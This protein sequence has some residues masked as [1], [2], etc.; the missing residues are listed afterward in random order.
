MKLSGRDSVK[1]VLGQI[2]YTAELYWLV[3]QKDKP[4]QSQFNLKQLNA[5]LPQLVKDVQTLRGEN[6]TRKKIFLFATLHYWIEHVTLLGLTLAAQGHD[7]TV[8]FMPYANW[9]EEINKFDLRRQNL[10]ALEVLKKAEK[11]IGVTSLMNERAFISLDEDVQ[12]RIEQVSMYDTQ[13]TAQDEDVDRDSKIF[14]MRME[15]NEAAARTALTWLSEGKPDVVIVPNGTIQEFG[16]VYQMAKHLDIPVNT[17]EFGDQRQTIW[18]A[19]NGEIMHQET[20]AMWEARREQEIDEK[21]LARVQ[22]LFGARQKGSLAENFTRLWQKTPAHGGQEARKELGLDERPVVLLATNV[23]GDS[24]T[25][26]RDLFTKSMESWISRTVQYFNG[27]PDVQLVIRVHPGEVLT[28]GISMVDVV[29]QVLPSLPEHIHLITP[30]E[31]VNT[32]DLMEA[33]DLG[34]VYTTTVGLE[35]AL[36]GLPVVV[37]AATHYRGRGFT[38]DP[39]SWVEYFKL[40]GRV[41]EAP[42]DF[43]LTEEQI[44]MAWQYAYYWFFDFPRP[45]PWHLVRMWDDYKERPLLDV[46]GEDGLK[47]YGATLGYLTGEPMDWSQIE[48]AG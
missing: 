39:N 14:K 46:L 13:Y 45:F 7:V 17:Y 31:K 27:R 42:A 11:V 37:N 2:P 18:L 1:N 16:V 24:L 4:L 23:L 20:D 29:H 5:R 12:Q 41:L 9:Q 30:E 43:R 22:R 40:L 35:M 6:A 26:G 21:Q 34:L 48:T 38:H 44:K 25:L 3:R 15:R 8:G 10:Y 47:Q 32:Y 19:Q 36:N 28:H 33:A